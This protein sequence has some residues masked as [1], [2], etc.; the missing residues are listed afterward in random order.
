M[1]TLNTRE[2]KTAIRNPYA[3]PGGYA[4]TLIMEDGETLCLDCARAEFRQIVQAA[5]DAE[6]GSTG[7]GWR[8]VGVD[9]HWEG[10]PLFCAHCNRELPSEYGDPEA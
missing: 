1:P 5:K 2:I 8:A 10:P 4:L 3:F 9:I 7:G 6:R